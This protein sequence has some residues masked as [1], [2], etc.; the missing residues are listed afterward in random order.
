MENN[1]KILSP[2]AVRLPSCRVYGPTATRL[3]L[4]LQAAKAKTPCDKIVIAGRLKNYF[5][6]FKLINGYL[7]TKQA[8]T[9]NPLF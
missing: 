8:I 4:N 2:V 1:S 6:L 3:S 7:I 5:R 9:E